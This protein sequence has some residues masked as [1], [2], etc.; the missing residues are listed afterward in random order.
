MIRMAINLKN[1]TRSFIGTLRR[2]RRKRKRIDK[3]TDTAN[4]FPRLNRSSQIYSSSICTSGGEGTVSSYK[5]LQELQNNIPPPPDDNAPLPPKR[6]SSLFT[7]G[8]ASTLTLR[9]SKSPRECASTLNPKRISIATSTFWVGHPDMEKFANGLDFGGE[10]MKTQSVWG[11]SEQ[12]S[13][14]TTESVWGD[15]PAVKKGVLMQQREKLWSRWKERYVILTRDYLNCFRRVA[16]VHRSGVTLSEM[17]SF[18]FKLRLADV[19]EIR[20]ENRRSGSLVALV[21]P[22]EP[23]ILLRVPNENTEALHQW[24]TL[25]QECIYMSK[26]RRQALR[27]H[28][29]STY[30]TNSTTKSHDDIEN[31]DSESK[32]KSSSSPTCSSDETDGEAKGEENTS[33]TTGD[34]RSA[35]SRISGKAPSSGEKSS[36]RKYSP[37]VVGDG[38]DDDDDEYDYADD[39]LDGG[40]SDE[41]VQKSSSGSGGSGQSDLEDYVPVTLRRTSS[42]GGLLSSRS[43][44]N[45]TLN[46]FVKSPWKGDMIHTH[47]QLSHS[48]ISNV[49]N[50][51]ASVS[52]KLSSG[53]AVPADSLLRPNQYHHGNSHHHQGSMSKRPE[54]WTPQPNLFY[55]TPSIVPSQWMNKRELPLQRSGGPPFGRSTVIVCSSRLSKEV[56]YVRRM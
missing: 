50:A 55:R 19:E 26:E 33:I 4:S 10:T 56:T 24:Y 36:H 8:G 44:S 16:N 29:M 20:W 52:R 35:S 38:D 31:G 6:S 7:P 13:G 18:I 41:Q 28:H 3:N 9:H 30:K 25:L 46:D 2:L 49:N 14:G 21:L 47:H 45:L 40:E 1:S 53:Y 34:R 43:G 15:P 51:N 48:E 42:R 39:K 17:G 12:G 37:V 23:R 27:N 5:Y 22:Q 11:T 54:S 32:T